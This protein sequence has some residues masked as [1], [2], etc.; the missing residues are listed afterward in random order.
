MTAVA[1]VTTVRPGVA[2]GCADAQYGHR[3]GQDGS[4]DSKKLSHRNAPLIGLPFKQRA[5]SSTSFV[6]N[7]KLRQFAPMI[8]SR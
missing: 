8:T 7:L 3:N 1:A 6:P 4:Q 5:I 2:G